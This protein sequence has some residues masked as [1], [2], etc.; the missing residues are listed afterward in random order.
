[1]KYY[2]HMKVHPTGLLTTE[3]KMQTYITYVQKTSFKL[4]MNLE[5]LVNNRNTKQEQKKF[6]GKLCM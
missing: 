5:Q 6:L 1:M 2:Q 4:F 3:Q